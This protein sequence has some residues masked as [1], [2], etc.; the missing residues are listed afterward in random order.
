MQFGARL[1]ALRLARHWTQVELA[2]RAGLS[3][4]TISH[5]EQGTRQP[6]LLTLHYLATAFGLPLDQFLGALERATPVL[7]RDWSL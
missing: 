1:T 7:N 5:L 4:G 6:S 3:Q 2:R